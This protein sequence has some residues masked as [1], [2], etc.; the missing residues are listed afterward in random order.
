MQKAQILLLTLLG[1]FLC[2]QIISE[3]RAQAP[4]RLE[5]LTY[6]TPL[7]GELVTSAPYGELRNNHF[8]SGVDYKIGGITG[9]SVRAVLDG[10]VVRIVVRPDG[11]GK[12]VYINHANGRTSVYAH[13]DAFAEPLAQFIRKKQY[14]LKRFDLD[15]SFKP[16]EFPVTKQQVI[17]YAGDSGNSG[18]PHLHFEIRDQKKEHPRNFYKDGIFK[19]LDTIAPVLKD[20][21]IYG[22][23]TIKGVPIAHFMSPLAR[24]SGI[25]KASRKSKKAKLFS[26]KPE[27][28]KDGDT[29]PVPSSFYLGIQASDAVNG[30]E[31]PVPVYLVRV[32]LDGACN[33]EWMR[34]FFDFSRTRYANAVEDYATAARD[35]RNILR[36]YKQKTWD[37]DFIKVCKMEGVISMKPNQIRKVNVRLE[38]ETGNRRDYTIFLKGSNQFSK[39]TLPKQLREDTSWFAL[40]RGIKK[41]FKRNDFTVSFP[42]NALYEG[43]LM[44]LG[45]RP[46][47]NGT[48]SGLID[49]SVLDIPGSFS[50]TPWHSAV[51]LSYPER[52]IPEALRNKTTWVRVK[53][54]D[55]GDSLRVDNVLKTELRD[56]SLQCATTEP[57][58]YSLTVDT[59]SPTI[60]FKNVVPNDTIGSKARIEIEIKDNLSGVAQYEALWNNQWVLAEYDPKNQ[61]LIVSVQQELVG[62]N[63]EG[64]LQINVRDR[65]GNFKSENISLKL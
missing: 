62:A 45:T 7:E 33:F 11:F 60:I 39:Y 22:I 27:G 13:L 3:T 46:I 10:Y 56:G 41:E 58:A 44:H 9:A 14:E 25:A 52:L 53:P 1:G 63:K 16:E 18:G 15:V 28:F 38:D 2:T 19:P 61:M 59:I 49:I 8:H 17:G 6:V 12:A 36:C 50:G 64:I 20:L 43:A 42:A 29:I 57:G 24:P 55:S 40:P 4:L 23:D 35:G 65:L 21:I 5:K 31:Q 30:K 54:S 47:K 26:S 34:D 51:R 37:V 48:V 32:L